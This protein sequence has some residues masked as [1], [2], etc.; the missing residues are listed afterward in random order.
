M[1]FDTR[2]KVIIIMSF[3]T[4]LYLWH[5]MREGK[6]NSPYLNSKPLTPSYKQRKQHYTAHTSIESS[7]NQWNA[8]DNLTRNTRNNKADLGLK[9]GLLALNLTIVWKLLS[10]NK[11]ILI[12][13]VNTS[14]YMYVNVSPVSEYNA[15]HY[16]N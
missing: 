1:S 13:S 10:N 16:K 15:S 2:F 14:S 8:W 12:T 3:D 9:H 6:R 4:R 11:N 5:A 7:W